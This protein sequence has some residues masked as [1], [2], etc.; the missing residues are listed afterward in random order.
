MAMIFAGIV[1]MAMKK[2]SFTQFSGGF[3]K[4]FMLAGISALGMGIINFLT[5]AASKN[6]TP[7]M[8]IWVPWII[9]TIICGALLIKQHKLKKL[10]MHAK[11]APWDILSMGVYDTLAWTF[12]A[13][14]LSQS[15]VSLTTAVTESYPA[16][17]MLLGIIVN[18]EKV[19]HHQLAGGILAL[20]CS[21][22]LGTMLA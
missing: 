12:Y 2:L 8:A 7:L 11:K 9:F 5:A 14:A 4:G 13:L 6:I 21:I 1:L 19:V 16:I 17:G 15:P 10:F 3:E 18:R 22:I 20:C